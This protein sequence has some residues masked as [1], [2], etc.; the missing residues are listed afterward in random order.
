[1]TRMNRQTLSKVKLP[2]AILLTALTVLAASSAHGAEAASKAPADKKKLKIV[3]LMGQSNMVGYSH[4]LTAWYLTQPMYVPP[5]KMALA[6]SRYYDEGYFY[7]QG[8]SFAYGSEE[9]NAKGKALLQARRAS[10]ATTLGW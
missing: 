9:F 7:W 8:V 6:K 10:R 5:P 1:M 3:F 2:V 4:P